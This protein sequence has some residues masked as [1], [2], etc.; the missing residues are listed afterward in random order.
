MC[1]A[2][3]QVYDSV[4]T[5]QYFS[6]GACLECEKILLLLRFSFIKKE[7]R[8]YKNACISAF[9]TEASP[10]VWYFFFAIC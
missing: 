8:S 3:V 4:P 9:Q 7:T 1:F 6:K 5:A 2:V 10:T